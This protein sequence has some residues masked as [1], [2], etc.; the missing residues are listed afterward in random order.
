MSLVKF[1][2]LKIH[3]MNNLTAYPSQDPKS[4]KPKM[5]SGDHVD[6]RETRISRQFSIS[7]FSR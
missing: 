4:N 5:K 3:L 7:S 1:E 6:I 2:T